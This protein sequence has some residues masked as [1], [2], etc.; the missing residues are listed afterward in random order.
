M[1]SE[2]LDKLFV[3][4]PNHLRFR[5]W[6]HREGINH[7]ASHIVLVTTLERLMLSSKGR[8][9]QSGDRAVDLGTDDSSLGSQWEAMLVSIGCKRSNIERF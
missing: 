4:A 1:A 2:R 7:N 6:C 5:Q 8:H 3:L 9:W